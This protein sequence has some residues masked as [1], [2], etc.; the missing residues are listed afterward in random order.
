MMGAS[1]RTGAVALVIGAVGAGVALGRDSGSMVVPYSA[2]GQT[3][4]GVRPTGV[5]LPDVGESGTVGVTAL[6]TSL[7]AY[8]DSG[9]YGR[10]L[11]AVDGAASSYVDQRL[12]LARVGKR[13]CT[14]S[15][16]AVRGQ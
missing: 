13:V 1:R 16:R 9:A 2:G 14:I 10:D 12:R 7:R 11:A 4:Y 8:H 6:A 5:G 3:L 15:Y